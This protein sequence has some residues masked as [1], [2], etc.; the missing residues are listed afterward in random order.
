MAQAWRRGGGAHGHS[1]LA[2]ATGVAQRREEPPLR[3]L[4]LLLLN[5][6][7][8]FAWFCGL[9]TSFHTF[10]AMPAFMAVRK[11]LNG[12]PSVSILP[13]PDQTIVKAGRA[14]DP[15]ANI[16]LV[17]VTCASSQV[18]AARAVDRLD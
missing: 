13:L 1:R 5:S 4:P 7:L 11:N 16:A 10:L 15:R 12:H 14:T 6:S 18:L 3:P 2:G 9:R 17:V 8:A